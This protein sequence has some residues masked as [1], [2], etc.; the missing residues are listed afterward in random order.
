MKNKERDIK[1]LPKWV[2]KL[3][4]DKNEEISLKNI[5]YNNLKS[6]H[7]ILFEHDKWFTIHGP[8]ENCE[9]AYGDYKLL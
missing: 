7:S 5:E 3:I 9:N 1:K 2:Q 6:A 8:I 4:S